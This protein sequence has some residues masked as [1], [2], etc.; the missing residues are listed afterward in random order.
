MTTKLHSNTV[1]VYSEFVDDERLI[2]VRLEIP[3]SNYNN[4]LKIIVEKEP[5]TT[6]KIYEKNS[7]LI[8]INHNIL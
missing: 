7:S 3:I 6:I 4:D 1:N 8:H 2:R 5:I